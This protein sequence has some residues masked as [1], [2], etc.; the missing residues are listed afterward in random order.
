[1]LKAWET[2]ICMSDM[3]YGL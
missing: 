1:M 2:R 3:V